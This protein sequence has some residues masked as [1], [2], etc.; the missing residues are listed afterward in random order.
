MDRVTL[1][2]PTRGDQQVAAVL[3]DDATLFKFS[4]GTKVTSQDIIRLNLLDE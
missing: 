2:H 3:N 4:D 1:I